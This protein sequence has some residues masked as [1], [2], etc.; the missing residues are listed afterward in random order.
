[1]S[2][3]LNLARLKKGSEVFEVVVDPKTAMLARQGRASVQDALKYP[4]IFSDAK[5]G[6]LASEQRTKAVFG[7]HDP[8]QVAE[9]IIKEG[10]IQVT[11]EYRKQQL[12]Q[13]RKQIIDVIH[14]NAVDPKTHLP[15]PVNRIEA[16]ME[17]AKV[18]IDE[19]KPAEQQVQEVLKQLRTTLPIK[20]ETKEIELIIPAKHAGRCQGIVRNHARVLKEE[21]Q[22]DGS[23][24]GIVEIPSGME[25]E[26]YDKLNSI[27]HG[28][29][30]SKT[31]VVK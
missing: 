28:E 22:G 2:N 25:Q 15:H 26:L 1:M 21:W 7:T 18:R 17:E 24:K 19:H 14:R 20:F 13:K 3:T 11:A 12:E 23:W 10:D 29:I 6:M 5:K 9:K 16:A 30:V 27:T 31:R 4:K 8:L